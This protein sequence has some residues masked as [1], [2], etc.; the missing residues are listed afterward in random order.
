MPDKAQSSSLFMRVKLP[1]EAAGEMH[2]GRCQP[3]A[4]KRLGISEP[5]ISTPAQSSSKAVINRGLGLG[6]RVE[7]QNLPAPDLGKPETNLGCAC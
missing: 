3:L 1:E 7:R 4:S 2:V 6:L 5:D